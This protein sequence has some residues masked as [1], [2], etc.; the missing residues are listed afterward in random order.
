M[1]VMLAGKC[2]YGWKM[3]SLDRYPESLDTWVSSDHASRLYAG[4]NEYGVSLVENNGRDPLWDAFDLVC[5]EE[6]ENSA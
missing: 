4:L 6:R 2:D 3:S 1:R 5:Y